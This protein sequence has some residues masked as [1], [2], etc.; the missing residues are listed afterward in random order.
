MQVSHGT[1][2]AVFFWPYCPD[3]KGEVGRWTETR[4]QGEKEN[5]QGGGERWKEAGRGGHEVRRESGRH[6]GEGIPSRFVASQ[7]K[8]EHRPQN[9]AH[10]IYLIFA[11]E[12]RTP[13]SESNCTF[14][15]SGLRERGNFS[16][17][18][19]PHT[20]SHFNKPISWTFLLQ[21]QRLYTC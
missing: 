2:P 11:C 3:M 21:R 1:N 5:M 9:P 15:L 8:S 19:S 6:E 10:S 7:L 20:L 12:R 13:L 4:M 17:C 18:L 16:P 14:N